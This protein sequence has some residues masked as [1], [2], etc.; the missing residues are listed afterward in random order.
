MALFPRHGE[1]RQIWLQSM[2]LLSTQSS[3]LELTD[4]GGKMQGSETLSL[5]ASSMLEPGEFALP[6]SPAHPPALTLL[7]REV[8]D[9]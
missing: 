6:A 9:R 7:S 2:S 3:R 8:P 4:E 5:S 1:E